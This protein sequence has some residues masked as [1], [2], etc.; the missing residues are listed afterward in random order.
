V[1]GG[2]LIA[3]RSIPV[4]VMTAFLGAP[5]LVA[6]VLSRRVQAEGAPS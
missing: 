2:V 1:L 4:G 5:V 3:P 6:L